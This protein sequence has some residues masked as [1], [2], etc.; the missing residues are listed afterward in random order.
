MAAIVYER[1][2]PLARHYP[3]D[4][5]EALQHA[6]LHWPADAR[7]KRINTLV[8]ELVRRGLCAPRHVGRVGGVLER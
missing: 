5:A 8:D 7:I 2:P 1:T 3:V 6:A 4:I